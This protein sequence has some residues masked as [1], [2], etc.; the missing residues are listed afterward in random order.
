VEIVQSGLYNFNLNSRGFNNFYNRYI[1]TRIDGRD[2]SLPMFSGSVDW[3]ALSLPLDDVDQLEFVRGP[4]AAL[5]G[6]GAVN[7]VLN[8]RTKSPR[9]SLGGTFRYTV[10]ELGTQRIE[11]RQAA[12]L[13]RGWYLKAM[14]GHHRSGDFTQ[15]RVAT[16]EYA[17]DTLPRDRIAPNLDGVRLSY[18][19]VRIDNDAG[20]DRLLSLEAGTA[21]EKGPVSLA[22]AARLQAIDVDQPWFRVNLATPRWN[23]LAYYTGNSMNGSQNLTAGSPVY[24]TGSQVTVEAQT[25]RQFADARGRV[26]AGVELGTQKT[27][28]AGPDGAQTSFDRQRATTYGSVFGQIEY[29]L[30]ARLNSVVSARWD[31]STLHDGRVSP[32]VAVVYGL[33]PEQMLRVT[34]G[35]AF[36]PANLTNYF[37]NIAAAP[38][39]DLSPVEAALRPVIGS[40]SLGL[41]SI[42]ILAVG[43]EQLR[44]SAV[45]SVEVGYHGVLGGRLLVDA[46]VYMN[47][48]E[49][50]VTTLLPQVGTSLGRL[51]PSFVPYTPPSALSPD[52]AT[53]VKTA[54]QAALPPSLFES[55]SNDATGRPVI[56]LLSFSNFGLART[57]G[58]EL[59]ATY[60]LPAGVKLQSSYTGFRSNVSDIPENPLSANTPAHQFSASTAYTHGRIDGAVRFRWVDKFEWQSGIFVGAV[61]SYTVLDLNASYKLTLHITAGADVAN[62]LSNE[63]Y[64]AFG[65]DLLGRRALGHVTYSW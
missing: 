30:A 12:S 41:G 23:V 10:G 53:T 32:R 4:G 57:A 62:L 14:G 35:R 28:S 20:R 27:D 11:A 37:L 33:A 2:P 25:N 42:P 52:A 56:A 7:G 44:V 29:R 54:L 61:P 63:H 49:D 15:S 45:D 21:H 16:A 39:L 38:P 8:I 60:V 6:A 50:F 17:P 5:Y 18:G 55:L 3:A 13:G 36:Q 58:V 19:S 48:I 43:N 31:N 47:R 51:N 26:I 59:G 1:L 9:E 40:T 64:E 34:Y 22:P 46:G 24:V 65:A